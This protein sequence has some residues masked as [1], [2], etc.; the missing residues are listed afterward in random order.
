MNEFSFYENLKTIILEKYENLINGRLS[1]FF[2][3]DE[4]FNLALSLSYFVLSEDSL[5]SE[6]KNAIKISKE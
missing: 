3:M 6:F 1:N 2:D 5:I 4:N